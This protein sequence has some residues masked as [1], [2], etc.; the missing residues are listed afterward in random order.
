MLVGLTLCALPG[1][2]SA[3][4]LDDYERSD[5]AFQEGLAF[6]ERGLVE[7]AIR[8]LERA[9]RL[10][11]GFVEAMVNLA[12]AYLARGDAEKASEWLDRAVRREP[13]YPDV[14]TV[15]G[16]VALSQGRSQE[17]LV[18]FGR[19]RRLAP[20]DIEA[21]TNLGATLLALGI[22]EEAR[23]VLEQ[24]FRLEPTR[25]EVALDLAIAQERRGDAAR[26]VFLYRRFL[27]LVGDDDPD[28]ERVERR[29][30]RL[31]PAVLKPSTDGDD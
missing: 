13:R 1:L 14:H 3:A 22:V 25:P 6:S 19:A 9:V 11:P 17:A 24:A 26:A 18:A 27:G 31:A 12:R 5:A 2:A 30:Q 16:L 23:A 29:V 28:R 10:D 8:A 15:R 4:E 21:L 20:E 7:P